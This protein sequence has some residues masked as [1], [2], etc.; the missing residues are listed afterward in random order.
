M[1]SQSTGL[2]QE[3]NRK[4]G[5]A[6]Y[7]LQGSASA[8]SAELIVP[9]LMQVFEP[10]SVIDVGCGI[11]GW[12]REF[13]KA[14]VRK[15]MGLEG[16]WVKDVGTAV[17]ANLIGVMDLNEPSAV[18]EKYDL[19]LCLEVAEHLEPKNS[20]K[21]VEFLCSLADIVVFSAAV[22]G[23]G[24]V[25]HINERWQ[26]EWVGIFSSKGFVLAND[27][28]PKL[29]NLPIAPWYCQNLLIFQRNTLGVDGIQDPT[30]ALLDVIH[31]RLFE[32]ARYSL[33]FRDLPI[34]FLKKIRYYLKRVGML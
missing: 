29:W 8:R 32:M 18:I 34:W 33:R 30:A 25:N 14:G 2:V 22:P 28:R 23:Q 13:Q 3:M 27:I 21:L 31:P 9:Y 5:K 16:A 17:D 24:G 26:S 12:L 4:Y 6:F 10:I 15:V 7:R 19:A 11:G 20:V 1:L